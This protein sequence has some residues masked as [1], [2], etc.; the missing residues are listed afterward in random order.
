MTRT[1]PPALALVVI[2]A[3][4]GCGASTPSPMAPSP[5]GPAPAPVPTQE[6]RDGRVALSDDEL[7]QQFERGRELLLAG[8]IEEAAAVFDKLVRLSPNGRIAPPSLYNGGTYVAGGPGRSRRR[9]RALQGPRD[10]LPAHGSARPPCCPRDAPPRLRRALAGA[11]DGGGGGARAHGPDGAREIDALGARA[12]GNVEQDKL[13]EAKKDVARARGRDRGQPPQAS[14]AN[15][16][17]LMQVSF[18]L[19]EVRRLGGRRENQLRP[20]PPPISG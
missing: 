8:R 15:P 14:R 7:A 5:T 19:G 4:S 18:A 9:N 2:L 3:L 16:I 13:D 11:G 12:L 17:E 1:L 20:T 6:V 10:T